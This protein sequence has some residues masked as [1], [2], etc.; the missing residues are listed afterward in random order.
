MP[1]LP[2]Q[3]MGRDTMQT[4]MYSVFSSIKKNNF[5]TIVLSKNL[6]SIFNNC[7]ERLCEGKTI[8][9]TVLWPSPPMLAMLMTMIF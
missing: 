9:V 4:I 7:F 6:S 5:C 8:A 2:V 1:Y 3:V